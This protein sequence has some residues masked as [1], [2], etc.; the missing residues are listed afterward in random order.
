MEIEV[1]GVSNKGDTKNTIV[2]NSRFHNK[3]MCLHR[4][5]HEDM[6]IKKKKRIETEAGMIQK[7][8]KDIVEDLFI[9]SDQ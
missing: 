4:A 1:I 9:V 3:E 7:N 6:N 5:L 8:K 2:N